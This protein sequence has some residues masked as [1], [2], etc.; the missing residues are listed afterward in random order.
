MIMKGGEIMNNE[1]QQGA[2][3]RFLFGKRLVID[4]AKLNYKQLQN[5]E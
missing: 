3:S 5:Y 1:A 2:I 4:K